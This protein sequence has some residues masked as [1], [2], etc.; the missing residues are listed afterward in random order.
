[1]GTEAVSLDFDATRIK[2]IR[3][4]LGETQTDFAKRL[5]VNINMVTRWE[6]GQAEP[7]RGRVLKALLDAEELT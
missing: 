2:R 3:V 7:M 6:T 1:M 4:L 5:G